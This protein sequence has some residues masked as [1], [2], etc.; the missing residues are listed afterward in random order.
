M[1]SFVDITKL[2]WVTGVIIWTL[3]PIRQ[4]KGWFFDFFL[5]LALMDPLSAAYGILTRTSLPLWVFVLFS[6]LLIISLIQEDSLRKYKYLF[7]ILP[8]V[9]VLAIPFQT[10]PI[11]L[12]LMTL[13]H[14]VL[15]LI[16]LRFLIVDYVNEKKMKPF[17]FMLVFYQLMTILKLFNLI[18]GFSEAYAFFIITTFAQIAFGLFFSIVREDKS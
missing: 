16:F 5:I 11:Y 12:V 2:L 17:Y 18:I 6:Y 10:K 14:S 9:F 8:L 3:P 7:I 13:E 1:M 4:Y 15:L